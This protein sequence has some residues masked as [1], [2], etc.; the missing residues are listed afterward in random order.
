MNSK[1]LWDAK[2]AGDY[3]GVSHQT[4][5]LYIRKGEIKADTVQ[6]RHNVPKYVMDPAE[7]IKWQIQR[8]EGSF[9]QSAI[10]A[11]T[12]MKKED[13]IENLQNEFNWYLEDVK[14]YGP[15]DG[16]LIELEP[17][18]LSKLCKTGPQIKTVQTL[19]N[20][21]GVY[22]LELLDVEESR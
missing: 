12:K 21:L 8:K 9:R 19:L 2:Q 18:D 6:T 1:N 16:E 20:I 13:V 14:R 7:V 11:Q 15:I 4:I 5:K 17:V 22:R 3:C 10:K